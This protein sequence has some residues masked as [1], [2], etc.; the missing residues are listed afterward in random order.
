MDDPAPSITLPSVTPAV[1]ELTLDQVANDPQA[2]NYQ[3]A[4][5][6]QVLRQANL[7]LLQFMTESAR[8]GCCT[9]CPAYLPLDVPRH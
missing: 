9:D 7:R 1:G 8:A 3:T 2:R 4:Q 5:D 6:E